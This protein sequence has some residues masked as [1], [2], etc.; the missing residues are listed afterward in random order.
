VDYQPVHDHYTPDKFKGLEKLD[1]VSVHLDHFTEADRALAKELSQASLQ[2]RN[3]VGGYV[4]DFSSSVKEGH[5]TMEGVEGLAASLK[6]AN[7][8]LKL[9]A[10]CYTM[11]FDQ[12]LNPY[13]PYFDS[14][15][16][17]TWKTADLKDLDEH[18]ATATRLYQKPLQ[19]GLYLFPWADLHGNRKD[20]HFWARALST[21]AMPMDILRFQFER[22]RQYLKDGR[23]EAVHILGSYATGELKTEAA[24][25]LA[26]WC[27]TV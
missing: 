3:L 15:S 17:W 1:R 16:L 6:S 20:P 26:D 4:D 27:L 13:L 18:V 14:V 25:W 8:S 11:H 10:V 5:V 2:C 9:N 7:P 22:A 24:R 19:L 12:D 23:I 21:E